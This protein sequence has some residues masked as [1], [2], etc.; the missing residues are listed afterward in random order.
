M[1]TSDYYLLS[2]RAALP[3]FM[4]CLENVAWLVETL[5]TVGTCGLRCVNTAWWVG[6]LRHWGV[7]LAFVLWSA[8]IVRLVETIETWKI[9]SEEHTSELQVRQYIVCR[10]MC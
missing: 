9:R 10:L 1:S 2:L 7:R 8:N 6:T 5:E 4:F 3:S